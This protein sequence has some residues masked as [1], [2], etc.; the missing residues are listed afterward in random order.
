MPTLPPAGSPAAGIMKEAWTSRFGPGDLSVSSLSGTFQG[1]YEDEDAAPVCKDS[2]I[3]AFVCNSEAGQERGAAGVFDVGGLA[4]HAARIFIRARVFVHFYSG[5]RRHG[6][7]QWHIENQSTIG[8]EEVFCISVDLCLEKA[9]SDLS[10]ES[11]AQWWRDRLYSG[12]I[13][14][15]GGGPSCETWTA[16]RL[17]EGGPK[18]VR[19][20][21]QPWGLPALSKRRWRQ[22]AVGTRLLTFLVSMLVDAAKLGCCGF[23]EHPAFPVWAMHKGPSSIWSLSIV[24][25]LARLRCFGLTTVDQCVFGLSAKKPTTFLLL[26]LSTVRQELLA[27]GDQGRCHHFG[28]HVRLQGKNADGTFKTSV[29]KI[30]PP[31]LNAALA[32]GIHRFSAANTECGGALP[33]VFSPLQSHDFTELDTVQPDFHG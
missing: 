23:L 5:Y 28:S 10:T 9:R 2:S 30:Y 16:A 15:V 22:V 20:A 18:V 25:R 6:D 12:I 29:A 19:T 32:K 31:A 33:D 14:G 21:D 17:Q 27:F 3:I 7:L 4:A 13:L 11:N 24:R 26:R 1:Q 8:M